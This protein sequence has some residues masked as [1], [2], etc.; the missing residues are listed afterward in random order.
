MEVELDKVIEE[1]KN[2]PEVIVVILF[3]K[4]ESSPSC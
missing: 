1:L 4:R 2:K 3:K